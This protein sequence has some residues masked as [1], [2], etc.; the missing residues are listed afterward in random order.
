MSAMRLLI[1]LSLATL[2][3]WIP[4]QGQCAKDRVLTWDDKA[5]DFKC[6]QKGG[7]S[8]PIDHSRPGKTFE[9]DKSKQDFCEQRLTNLLHGC[10][11]GL[12]GADCRRR[13]LALNA[14]CA[15]GIDEPVKS[16][17]DAPP[18]KTDA[19]VCRANFAIMAKACRQQKNVVA[20][21]GEPRSAD[22][23]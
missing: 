1:M 21:P 11:P 9:S 16:G 7:E 23:C 2:V 19:K 22:T 10:P 4:V 5:Q 14:A 18:R 20:K 12:I 8:L 6:E 15:K 13:A 17:S 3:A